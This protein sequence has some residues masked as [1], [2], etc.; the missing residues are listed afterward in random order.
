MY[1]QREGELQ[2]CLGQ[3]RSRQEDLIGAQDTLGA[4]GKRHRERERGT[5]MQREYK[6]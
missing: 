6:T 4:L 2:V 5:E 3:A 1:L